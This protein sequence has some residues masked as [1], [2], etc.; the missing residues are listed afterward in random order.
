[1]FPSRAPD[2][3]D[4][5]APAVVETLVQRLGRTVTGSELIA[6]ALAVLGSPR[7]RLRH[8]EALRLDYAQLPWPRDASHFARA[9]A[10]GRRFDAALHEHAPRP[11]TWT[12][13]LADGG[14]LSDP[15][16]DAPVGYDRARARVL[17]EGR[18]L[19]TGVTPPSWDAQVGHHSMVRAA[20]SAE[21][22]V[23]PTL[24]TLCEAVARAALWASS[25]AEADALLAP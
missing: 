20:L 3:T 19:L 1:V 13:E 15:L 11:S 23:P 21:R 9:V 4:N 2:G 18:V 12:W 22:G 5:V 14:A 8:E 10:L 16:G 24:G 25:E 17:Q 6:Y 7:F